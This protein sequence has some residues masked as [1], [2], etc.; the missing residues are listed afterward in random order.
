MNKINS[1]LLFFIFFIFL[2]SC[3][4]GPSKRIWNDLSKE[5]EIAKNKENTKLIFSS[6]EK[7][8]KEIKN[9][10][11]KVITVSKPYRNESWNQQ[12]LTNGNY[13]P[14]LSY[15]NKKNL[16]FKSKKLGKNSFDL[17]DVEFQPIIENDIVFF[18]DPSGTLFSYSLNQERLIW[19]YNFYKKRYKNLPK[20]INFHISPTSLIASDNLGF[21][22]SLDKDTGNI[23][24]AKS[25]GVPF[26]SNIKLDD[27]NLFLVNQ[28]NKFYVIGE[29]KGKQRLDLETLPSFLKSNNK[30]NISLDSDKKNVFF[31]TS[32]AEIYSLNYRNRSINWLFNLTGGSFDKQVDLFY[33]S[34]I[35]YSEDEL[36][37][38]TSLSSFSMD[39]NNGSVNWEIPFPTKIKPVVLKEYVFLVSKQ[40]FLIS[41]DRKKGEVIWSHNLFK[42]SK[43]LK[44]NKTG[45][46]VS[47]LLI[48]DQIFITTKNGYFL[49]LDYQNGEIIN[50]AKVSK[51][52]FSKPAII[53]ETIFVIDNK[54]RILQF[55]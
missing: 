33:S 19:K 31:I 20:E 10:N 53:D 30:S 48:S 35:V 49:F 4:F 17:Y 32:A 26:K 23:Q 15:Q 11:N 12:N 55:N 44:H 47:I 13:V 5:L 25:Y 14:H 29:Q 34:P 45:D 1:S 22:Y 9:N 16:I 37:L 6:S 28:D 18:Y 50:Y 38:S 21:V 54:M 51:G 7:F 52:F 2:F 40:G 41:L 27:S 42:T 39:S 24:W 8:Q 43:K 46:I 36:F 3:S